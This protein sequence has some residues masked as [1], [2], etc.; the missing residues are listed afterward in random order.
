MVFSERVWIP[1]PAGSMEGILAY[2]PE[3]SAGEGVVVVPPHPNFAGTMENNVVAAVAVGLAHHGFL[4]LRFNYPGVGRS[5]LQLPPCDSPIDFWNRVEEQGRFEVPMAALEAT[6]DFLRDVP[7]TA[8]AGIHLV[9]YSFG[10]FLAAL[11]GSRRSGVASVTAVAMPWVER[12]SYTPLYEGTPEL[13]LI[14][15]SKDFV[16]DP[17]I[18]TRESRRIPHRLTWLEG[19]DHFFRGRESRLTETIVAGLPKTDAP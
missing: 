5:D 7:G 14:S 1:Q 10:G 11:M 2:D 12:Y 17:P 19:E 6:M 9:G 8:L 3:A 4:T 18:Y 16:F 13:H 15:G